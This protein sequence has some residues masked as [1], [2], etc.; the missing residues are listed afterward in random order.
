MLIKP[1]VLVS[2]VVDKSTVSWESGQNYVPPNH[3]IASM[4]GHGETTSAQPP[5]RDTLFG[6]GTLF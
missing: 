1:T 5:I 3:Q 6:I 2:R 4:G